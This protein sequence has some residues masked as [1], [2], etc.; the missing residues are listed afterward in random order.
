M[1]KASYLLLA[2]LGAVGRLYLS[3]TFST[4]AQQRRL[5]GPL[6][7]T[8]FCGAFVRVGSLGDLGGPFPV[9]FSHL[10]LAV[11]ECTP[12]VLKDAITRGITYIGVVLRR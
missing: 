3:R 5:A 10:L 4:A 12:E 7:P 9:F 11:V 6:H 2:F 8:S 1:G